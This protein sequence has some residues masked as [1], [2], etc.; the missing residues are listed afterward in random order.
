MGD[1][2]LN[3]Q[4]ELG[5]TTAVKE[6]IESGLGFSILSRTDVQR[7]LEAGVLVQVEGL[8]IPWSFK[9]IRHRSAPLS[10]VEKDFYEFVLS[11]REQQ[12][13]GKLEGVA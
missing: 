10:M 7:K 8:S 12:K 11:M 5:S 4:M 9:L 13:V 2:P 1:I 6:A 3:V